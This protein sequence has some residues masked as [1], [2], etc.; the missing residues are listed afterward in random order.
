M[1]VSKDNFEE[2]LFRLD[3]AFKNFF[4]GVTVS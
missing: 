3:E 2:V 4:I 1:T